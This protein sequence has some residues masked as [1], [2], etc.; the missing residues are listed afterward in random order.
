MG[1]RTAWIPAKT[2]WPF[3]CTAVCVPPEI[4]AIVVADRAAQREI[5][6]VKSRLADR[7]RSE[8]ERLDEARAARRSADQARIEAEA[9]A[10]ERDGRERA[11]AR[12]KARAAVRD[13]RR[14]RAA[15]A[16]PAAIAAYLA[17]VGGGGRR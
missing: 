10:L 4:E 3:R 8:R 14:A 17:V 6:A 7:L 1:T 9:L 2:A 15:A 5:D 11:D 16:L 12:R 13:T